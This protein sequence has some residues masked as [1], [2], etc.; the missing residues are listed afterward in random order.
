MQQ[1]NKLPLLCEKQSLCSLWGKK[2]CKQEDAFVLENSDSNKYRWLC[3][4]NYTH[5]L[6][7]KVIP[8]KH[9]YFIT[10]WGL[11]EQLWISCWNL[12]TSAVAGCLKGQQVRYKLSGLVGNI[13]ALVILRTKKK[14]SFYCFF[15]CLTPH[16]DKHKS[17]APFRNIEKTWLHA[18][19]ACYF[20]MP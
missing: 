8:R 14:T 19:C 12:K 13:L 17:S 6:V 5:S 20:A 9:E 15:F 18:G 11:L 10:A 1:G 7:H 3:M 4:A 16:R 2:C